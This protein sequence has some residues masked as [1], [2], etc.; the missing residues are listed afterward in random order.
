MFVVRTG[1]GERNRTPVIDFG[2]RGLATRRHLQEW[3]QKWGSNPHALAYE[4]SA[5]PLSYS[6]ILES[7]IR[8]EPMMRSFADFCLTVWLR[9]Q[10]GLLALMFVAV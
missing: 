6:A 3:S 9:A 2:D 10:I 8:V 7:A 1:A 4:A 5:L